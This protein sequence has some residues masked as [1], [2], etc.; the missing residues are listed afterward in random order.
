MFVM[1]NLYNNTEI[2]KWVNWRL[3]KLSNLCNIK[4][5]ILIVEL[6]SKPDLFIPKVCPFL[7]YHS[8]HH[9]ATFGN[10]RNSNKFHLKTIY[11]K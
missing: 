10:L 1:V 2:C 5:F 6:N 8:M 3:G 11:F 4:L 9:Y 7:H